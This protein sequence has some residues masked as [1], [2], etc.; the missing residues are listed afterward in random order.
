MRLARRCTARTNPK[1]GLGGCAPFSASDGLAFDASPATAGGWVAPALAVADDDLE[2]EDTGDLAA[3]LAVGLEGVLAAY[4]AVDLEAGAAEDEEAEAAAVAGLRAGAD[5]KSDAAAV[6]AESLDGMRLGLGGC[7]HAGTGGRSAPL[8]VSRKSSIQV[9]AD[10]EML[11][12]SP[13][14]GADSESDSDSY[15]VSC[16]SIMGE[17]CGSSSGASGDW[18][19]RGTWKASA[20]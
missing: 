10:S 15:S 7:L 19:G 12:S 3:A 11:S 6:M 16:G 9:V 17:V 5:K 13:G 8:S 14:S 20:S 1:S 18:G 2:V 4:L